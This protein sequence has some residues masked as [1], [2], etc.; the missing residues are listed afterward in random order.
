MLYDEKTETDRE[1]NKNVYHKD[2][3]QLR[4]TISIDIPVRCIKRAT[5]L[6]SEDMNNLAEAG[7]DNHT[8]NHIRDMVIGECTNAHVGGVLEAGYIVI[9][10]VEVHGP[11]HFY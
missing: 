5:D 7:P 6:V 9:F 1:I 4:C 10:F 2:S 11:L 3:N 8:L